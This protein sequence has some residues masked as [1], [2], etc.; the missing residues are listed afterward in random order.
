MEHTI[1]HDGSQYLMSVA[2]NL[3]DDVICEQ[4]NADS[5]HAT[6]QAFF[7][8]YVA[9]HYLSYGEWFVIN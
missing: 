8:D 5:L 3:M 9:R 4:I 6:E 2:R 7:D 1:T